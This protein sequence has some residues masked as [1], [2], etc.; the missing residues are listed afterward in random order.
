MSVAIME[1][2]VSRV[3]TYPKTLQVLF[4][5]YIQ[6]FTAN[7]ASKN[8]LKKLCI[9]F[10]IGVERGCGEGERVKYMVMAGN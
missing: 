5:K 4:I 10:H 2:M 3:N 6:L 8:Y 7:H 9:I 1:M